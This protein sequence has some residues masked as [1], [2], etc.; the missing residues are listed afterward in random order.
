MHDIVVFGAGKIARGFLGHLLS[1]SGLPFTFIDNNARLVTLLRERR[2]Y[3]IHVMGHSE[4]D[5][6]VR[7]YKAFVSNEIWGFLPI[8][9]ESEAVFTSVGGKNLKEIAKSLALG[10]QLRFMSENDRPQ[11]IICCE[12]W[13]DPASHLRQEMENWLPQSLLDRFRKTVGIVE[14][15][16][17]RSAVD[18]GGSDAP[19]DPLVVNV[20]DYWTLPVDGAGIVGTLPRIEGL[21]I[22]RNFAGMLTRKLFT[23]NAANATVSYL[24]YLKGYERIDEAVADSEILRILTKVY[25]ETSFGL[26]QEF[27]IPYDEE[28][29]FSMTSL[30]KLRNPDIVDRIQRNARDPIRKLGPQ[31]RLVGPALLVMKH[32]RRPEGLATAIAAALHYADEKDEVAVELQRVRK[33]KGIGFVLDTICELSDHKDLKDLIC[34]EINELRKN[35]LL[36]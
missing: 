7:G 2:E 17:L 35:G 34:S 11:N 30:A 1:V 10:V 29:E 36:R 27:G 4:K 26:S 22:K 16:V 3:S 13:V 20:Q 32:G 15:V 8:L 31:D 6:T 14:S 28:Y 23:Y 21:Q 33:E 5:Y 18:S 25:E 19:G 9:A 12:N 24:G